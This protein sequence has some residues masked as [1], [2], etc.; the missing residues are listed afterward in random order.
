MTRVS[1]RFTSLLTVVRRTL[2][3]ACLMLGYGIWLHA[4]EAEPETTQ[5]ADESAVA[6]DSETSQNDAAQGADAPENPTAEESDASADASTDDDRDAAEDSTDESSDESP[7]GGTVMLLQLQGAIGP[8]T[9]DFVTR[10]IEAAEAANATLMV[11]EMDTPGGLDTA[12][13]E[14]IQAILASSVPVATY[15][16]PQGARA[17]S[18]GTYILYASH[19]AAMA[20]ATNLGAA[21]P[22]AI[23][24]P[25]P[26]APADPAEE[27]EETDDVDESDDDDDGDENDESTSDDE[28]AD[29]D[30]DED[31]AAPIDAIP[32][33]SNASERKAINDAVAY[34]RGLAELRDRNADWAEDAVRAAESLSSRTALEMNVID[35]IAENLADLLQ[36]LDG[37]E[38]EIDGR[39]IELDTT[40][41]IYERFEPD[42]RTRLLQVISN[43]TVAYMLMLLGIYGLLFEGYNPG[44]IVPGVVGAIAL[45][46]ALF[47]FQVLPVNYAGLALIVLGVIL[48]VSEFLVPSF[49][50]L[51]MGGI[52]AFVFGSVI[53]IDSDIPGFG[54]SI[55]LIATIALSGA[56]VML[57][58]VWFAVKS[59]DRPVVSGAEEMSGA[60]AEALQD[61]ETRGPV[62]VH[63]ERWTARTDTP[64][65]AGQLLEVVGVEGL[66][67]HVRPRNSS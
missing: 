9:S 57:G 36:Q 54:V 15:V 42:W 34:I 62:W 10:G 23:G 7:S 65:S 14:I 13:R 59:R 11:L 63:G 12:M 28:A 29:E 47:S 2:P 37:W 61:F 35:L 53:L 27:A 20:P 52:A 39:E 25:A 3:V 32:Q 55:P 49:G 43:P 40:G 1:L 4:Q 50:A 48:M 46:L 16:S 30:E 44:A 66:T 56:L 64:V 17:A 51:G 24:G 67:L 22:V 26:A 58:I 21:T 38:L 8:A 5:V 18:A 45:L 60:R 19:I 33:P 41:L 6:D 31:E